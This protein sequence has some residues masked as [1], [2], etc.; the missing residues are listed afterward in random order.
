MTDVARPEAPSALGLVGDLVGDMM[1]AHNC[2]YGLAETDSKGMLLDLD[3]QNTI[4][5]DSIR[6]ILRFPCSNLICFVIR[7]NG[8]ARINLCRRS[9]CGIEA[10]RGGCSSRGPGS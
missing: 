5:F 1:L 7:W 10:S 2:D 6:S 4:R 8:A 3:G 9:E